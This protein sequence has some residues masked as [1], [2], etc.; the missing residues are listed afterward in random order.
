MS[1]IN[2]KHPPK[3]AVRVNSDEVLIVHVQGM[4]LLNDKLLEI[5]GFIDIKDS[6]KMTRAHRAGIWFHT[7][8]LYVIEYHE[9]EHKK[10]DVCIECQIIFS[11]TNPAAR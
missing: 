8:R 10:D 11:E 3:I 9:F 1:I 7:R 6:K 2:L 5:V 4:R